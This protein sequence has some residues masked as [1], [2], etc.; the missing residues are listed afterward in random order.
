MAEHWSWL[1]GSPA[2][3]YTYSPPTR[4]SRPPQRPLVKLATSAHLHTI[5][6]TRKPFIFRGAL[7]TC[8]TSLITVDRSLYAAYHDVYDGWVNFMPDSFPVFR[9]ICSSNDFR[10]NTRYQ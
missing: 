10:K 1:T 9:E 3:E 7:C 6:R 8:Q 4:P 5:A 2:A